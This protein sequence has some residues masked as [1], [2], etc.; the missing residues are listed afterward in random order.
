MQPAVGPLAVTVRDLAV[1]FPSPD[2]PLK[3]LDG[4]SLT[5]PAGS[6]LA[7]VGPNGSG[8]STLLRVVAGL[9][10]PSRGEVLLGDGHPPNPG[11]GRVGLAF[12]QPR[13]IGWRS[14]VDNVALPLE[15]AGASGAQ[16]RA[17]AMVSL[18]QVGLGR[19]ARLRPAELSGGMQ[20][21]AALARALITDP[22]VLLLDEPFSALD[23]LTREAF[24]LE[25]E[26]LWMAR[27]RTVLMVTH[28]VTEAIQL[29]DAVAVMSA[30]PGRIVRVVEVDLPHP[31][32]TQ[33]LGSARAAQI[34]AEIRA[35]LAAVHPPELASW[36][37]E[38]PA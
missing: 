35:L 23:A 16:R 15:L 32:P 26:R 25:L 4:L 5:V 10:P 17:R 14:A 28:A 24:N 7:V 9:L 1:T 12:Q 18:E 38:V 30:R 36:L 2:G 33:L 31:R 34:G 22:Q 13:L 8:K 20:Q 37:A 27:S 19:A 3:A 6:F 21:R 11:D 29:A